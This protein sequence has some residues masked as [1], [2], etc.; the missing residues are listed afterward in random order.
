MKL[1]I[2]QTCL[3]FV[4]IYVHFTLGSPLMHISQIFMNLLETGHT[5]VYFFILLFLALS[6]LLAFD[7]LDQKA[8]NA[9]QVYV[10]FVLGCIF[11]SLFIIN[12][13]SIISTISILRS[14]IASLL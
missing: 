13:S 2:C 5:G 4:D 7:R 14:S 1:S 10:G 9:S 12:Y 8:H 3:I 11:Q 6:G